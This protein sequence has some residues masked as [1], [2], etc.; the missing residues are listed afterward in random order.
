M[1]AVSVVNA[2]IELVSATHLKKLGVKSW[3]CTVAHQIRDG[4]REVVTLTGLSGSAPML[5]MV[6]PYETAELANAALTAIVQEK[7]TGGY[8]VKSAQV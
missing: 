8:S 5:F 6:K 3:Q 2:S 1:T 7:L 4:Q